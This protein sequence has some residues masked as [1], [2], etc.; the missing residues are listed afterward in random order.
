MSESS[1]QSGGDAILP[2]ETDL[3]RDINIT[4]RRDTVATLPFRDGYLLEGCAAARGSHRDRSASTSGRPTRFR[5]PSL[6]PMFHQ[7]RRSRASSMVSDPPRRTISPDPESRVAT[8]GICEPSE[9]TRFVDKVGKACAELS[10]RV[11]TADVQGKGPYHP[12]GRTGS[13]SETLLANGPGKGRAKS[14]R[15]STSDV[16]TIVIQGSPGEGE[17]EGVSQRPQASVTWSAG[18]VCS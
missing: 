4:K 10:P 8:L 3:S 11:R 13:V 17:L 7:P 1:K 12:R 15:S 6:S 9:G 5:R 16:P 14:P 18:G 2:E